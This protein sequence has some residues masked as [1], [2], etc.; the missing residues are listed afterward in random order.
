MNEEQERLLRR[1][2]TL[3]RRSKTVDAELLG[4]MRET[5]DAGV[6]IR[7]IAEAAEVTHQTVT[8]RLSKEQS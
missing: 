5:K 8:N 7:K 6:S 2:R 1:V 3:A 4:A